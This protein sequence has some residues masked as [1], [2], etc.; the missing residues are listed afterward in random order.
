M[1]QTHTVMPKKMRD[2]MSGDGE[3]TRCAFVG[4]EDLVGECGGRVTREHAV[5]YAGRKVQ[6]R[7]AIIPCCAKH[8][9]VDRYQDAPGTAPKELRLWV[10]LNRATDEELEALP[11]A[12]L[13]RKRELMNAQIGAYVS[14][15]VPAS[16][17]IHY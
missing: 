13:L 8:H 17:E 10:A 14:P 2:A 15:P 3:Y 12:N 7:W 6:E 16:T 4:Y 1:R 9:G 11:R 5:M